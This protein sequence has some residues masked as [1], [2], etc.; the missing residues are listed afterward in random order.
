MSV[1]EHTYACFLI[2]GRDKD[3]ISKTESY[4]MKER[5]KERD[6]DSFAFFVEWHINLRGS[7]NARTILVVLYNP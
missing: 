3:M 7:F 2:F 4:C 6:G 1:F 5:E